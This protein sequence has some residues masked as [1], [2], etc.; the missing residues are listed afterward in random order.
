MTKPKLN[1]SDTN[2]NGSCDG[3]PDNGKCL[4]GQGDD[5]GAGNGTGGVF[6]LED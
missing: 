6:D 2:W 5:D 1:C 3:C 4:A